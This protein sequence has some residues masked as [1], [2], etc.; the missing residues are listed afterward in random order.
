MNI[1]G[2]N[3]QKEYLIYGGLALVAFYVLK[4]YLGPCPP[5]NC[6]QVDA[7]NQAALNTVHYGGGPSQLAA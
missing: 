3:I 2:F 5:C 1:L 6:A 4:T 7:A